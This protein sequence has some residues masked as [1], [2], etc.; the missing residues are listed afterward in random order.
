MD[1]SCNPLS[2]KS[3]SINPTTLLNLGAGKYPYPH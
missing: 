3:F 2:F 1:I